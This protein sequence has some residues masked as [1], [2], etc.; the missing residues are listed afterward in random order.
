[1]AASLQL[2]LV[3]ALTALATAVGTFVAFRQLQD[4]DERRRGEAAGRLVYLELS[5]N[6]RWVRAFRQGHRTSGSLPFMTS[7]TWDAVQVDIARIVDRHLIGTVLLP[8]FW[9]ETMRRASKEWDIISKG[10]AK[11]A[12]YER[13]WF[14]ELEKA[15]SEATDVLGPI[16]W[17]K[18]QLERMR[19]ALRE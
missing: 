5:K 1:M 19:T 10:Y 3:V 16:V 15:L 11:I 12:G 14:D 17:D 2:L 7:T 9:I 4:R 8:Y 6:Y 18:A 13:Q